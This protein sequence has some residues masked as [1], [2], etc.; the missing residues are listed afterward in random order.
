MSLFELP[1]FVK[2][3]K[4][5]GQL[6]DFVGGYIYIWVDLTKMHKTRITEYTVCLLIYTKINII[7]II[8]CD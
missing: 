3:L 5:P 2:L 1:H 6:R 7:K 4:L 8:I